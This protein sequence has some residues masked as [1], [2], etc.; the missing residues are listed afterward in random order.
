[1][2]AVHVVEE[3]HKALEFLSLDT[4]LDPLPLKNVNIPIDCVDVTKL[5][6]LKGKILR[7]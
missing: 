5:I 2:K 3:I 7:P 6:L 4:E 1:M